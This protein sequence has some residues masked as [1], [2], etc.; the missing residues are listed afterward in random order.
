MRNYLTLRI[1]CGLIADIQFF[2]LQ[3]LMDFCDA[4]GLATARFLG[5]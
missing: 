4:P 5:R 1:R 3:G 2:T